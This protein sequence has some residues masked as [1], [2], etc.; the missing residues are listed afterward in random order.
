MAAIPSI[1]QSKPQSSS[2]AEK[3]STAS[4]AEKPSSTKATIAP[5]SRPPRSNVSA[6]NLKAGSSLNASVVAPSN[7]SASAVPYLPASR[8]ASPVA[9]SL[10][11]T[12]PSESA[13]QTQAQ[14]RDTEAAQSNGAANNLL[15]DFSDAD[16]ASF[17][18]PSAS[19][20][21]TAFSDWQT[22]MSGGISQANDLLGL[23]FSQVQRQLST[24]FK[25]EV[26]VSH[27]NVIA[28]DIFLETDI[29]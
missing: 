15:L 1:F 24:P 19:G 25:K 26:D 9:P 29:A 3:S 10:L 5:F 2:S 28:A 13:Q 14:S 27:E 4:D 17:G 22:E 8:A 7:A 18:A 11:Y 21:G 20:A 6:S 16:N 23:E 12:E